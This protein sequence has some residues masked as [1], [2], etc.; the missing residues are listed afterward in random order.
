MIYT[1]LSLS[2]LPGKRYSFHAKVETFNHIGLF[3][4]LSLSGI[5]GRRH[6]FESKEIVIPDDIPIVVQQGGSFGGGSPSMWDEPI[7]FEDNYKLIKQ[8]D[9]EMFEILESLTLSGML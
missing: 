2:G 3:T 5:P 4:E 1:Q 8:E 7:P 6:S 9:R